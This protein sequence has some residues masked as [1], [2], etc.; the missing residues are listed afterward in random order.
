M[1]DKFFISGFIFVIFANIR[2]VRPAKLG[3][4]QEKEVQNN[5][6][7]LDLQNNY[8]LKLIKQSIQNNSTNVNL[9]E[10]NTIQF[11]FNK[12]IE[13]NSSNIKIQGSES[14]NQTENVILAR[15]RNKNIVEILF[16]DKLK[17]NTTYIISFLEGSIVDTNGG[18]L[19]FDL[20]FSTG[21]KINDYKM[22]GKVLDLFN[23][24]PIDKTYV[25]L[26]K[27]TEKEIKKN[28]SDKNILNCSSPYYFT[29]CDKNGEY[30]FKNISPGTYFICAGQ[31]NLDTFTSNNNLYYGFSSE[32]ITFS[33][34]KTEYKNIDIYALKNDISE[35]K[36]TYKKLLDKKI[37]IG[38][39]GEIDTFSIKIIDSLK[40]NYSK[41]NLLLKNASEIKKNENKKD[42]ITIDNDVLGLILNDILPCKIEI[43]NKY[44]EIIKTEINIS[45]KETRENIM[46]IGEFSQNAEEDIKVNSVDKE[47]TI[48]S[49]ANFI[50]NSKKKIE[51]INKGKVNIIISDTDF[52]SRRRL[53]NFDITNT[54]NNVCI[55][56]NKKLDDIVK[57]IINADEYDK[58]DTLNKKNVLITIIFKEGAIRYKNLETNKLAESQVLFLRE[59][60]KVPVEVNLPYNNF[61]VE[62]LDKNLNIVKKFVGKIE[63]E[64]DAKNKN[65]YKFYFEKVPF[66]KY[67]VR[68]FA[69]NGDK[70]SPGNIFKNKEHDYINIKSEITI[71][72][73]Q[74]E[75][76][77]IE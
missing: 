26:Y 4:D 76:I 29:K 67:K 5:E 11:T 3:Q 44:G 28:I 35:F 36:I 12:E 10:N 23:D 34:K 16:K 53:E 66:G 65:N 21:D 40:E 33:D 50:I 32:F 60:L 18:T 8:T 13:V 48:E 2:C 9:G 64:S 49:M 6:K 70:W 1:F 63:K 39:N 54:N 17:K 41:Y 69:W 61:K 55:N 7:I 71:N 57:E 42:E 30:N 46:N 56:F 43:K 58:Y 14:K 31:I 47:P 22:E 72:D 15:I 68:Y 59:Y 25:F 62:L 75:K 77:I 20:V 38:T 51:S 24:T 74:N 27:L 52:Y 37:T 45:L 19:S 73:F